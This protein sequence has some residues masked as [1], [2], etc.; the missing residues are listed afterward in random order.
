MKFQFGKGRPVVLFDLDG[1]LLP[2]DND[3][4]EKVYFKGLC[5]SITELSPEQLIADIWAG[6]K[7]MACNDGSR[8][9]REAFA[10]VFTERSGID[11][12]R[13]EERFLEYYRTDFQ[14][15]VNACDVSEKSRKIV[16]TLQKKGYMT[17]VATNPIFPEIATHSRLRWIGLE[18]DEFPLVTT[19]ENS[20]Y[21]KPNPRYY[22]N[23]CE[24]LGVK[25]EQCIMIGNDVEEDGCAA[26]LGIRVMLVTDCLLNKKN[27]STESF[28]TGTLEEV[29]Q[30]A[31][32]L[33]KN[34]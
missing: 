14:N 11:Y 10:D 26:S 21:A 17:A 3:K 22:Q 5:R 28:E 12:Y 19:F 9:N 32:S 29:L 4:F 15:C 27:L 25:P 23:V 20:C 24:R 30:W 31:E 6:T 13:N 18:P 16:H 1:T 34:E 33:P 8:T 2:M 7:A